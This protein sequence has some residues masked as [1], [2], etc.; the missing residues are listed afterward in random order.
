LIFRAIDVP[1][2]RR[3]QDPGRAVVPVALV[4]ALGLDVGVDPA[5]MAAS[6][7]RASCW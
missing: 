3:D 4:A 2:T 5:L 7:P 1:V 6:A